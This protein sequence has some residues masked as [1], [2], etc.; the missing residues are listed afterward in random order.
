MLVWRICQ[1]RYSAFDG[2]G[3]RRA[4]GRWHRQGVPLIYTSDTLALAA[5]EYFVRLNPGDADARLIAVSANIPDNL[6]V[7]RVQIKNLPEDWNTYP[8]PKALQDAGM[9]WLR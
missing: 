6:A 7:Q 4:N 8:A 2:E 3:A 5:L 9:D 1:Q